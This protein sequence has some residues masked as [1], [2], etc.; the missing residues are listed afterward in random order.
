MA[1]SRFLGR[2]YRFV[3]RNASWRQQTGGEFRGTAPFLQKL[4]TSRKLHQTI[5][6]VTQELQGRWHFNTCVSA[7]MN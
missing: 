1:C 4:A 3:M 7:I 6:R 2:V 5:R